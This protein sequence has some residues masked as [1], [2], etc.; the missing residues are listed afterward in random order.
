MPGQNRSGYTT[1]RWIGAVSLA[2]VPV[3]AQPQMVVEQLP[4]PFTEKFDDGD[5]SATAPEAA[6][7][8]SGALKCLAFGQASD[9]VTSL[10][11]SVHTI[12]PCAPG[13]DCSHSEPTVPFSVFVSVPLGE[14]HTMLRLAESLL[15]EAM[16]LQL[17][18]IEQC[19][20]IVAEQAAH[21]YSPWQQRQRPVQG[22]VHGLYVFTAIS[23]WLSIIG[24]NP[25]Q[26]SEDRAY[27]DRRLREIGEEIDQVSELAASPGLTD[28]GRRL[29]RSLL[30]RSGPDPQRSVLVS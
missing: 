28:F 20:P 17:T 3:P 26:S 16:H 23:E 15:H 4:A 13:Y 24:A 12:L 5:F 18:L 6:R 7:A 2:L 21:G 27:A 10:I 1:A 22:L 14:R 30:D 19:E 25:E 8:I 29:V 9:A 11:R